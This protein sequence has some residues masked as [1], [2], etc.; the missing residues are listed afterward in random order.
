[1]GA[2][3]TATVGVVRET[4]DDEH[5]VALTPDGVRRVSALG[6][7]VLVET[8]AGR[9]A[10]FGDAD[11][12]GAGATIGSRDQVYA[13]SDLVLCVHAPVDAEALHEG[14]WLIGLL[15][16]LTDPALVARLAGAQVTMVSL[17]L[18]PR[19]LSRAQA[20]D[21]L[22]SQATVAGYKAALIAA[23]TYGGFFPMLMTAAGTTRP[24]EVLVLGAGVAGL[25]AIATARRLGAVV[26][27]HDVREAARADIASTGAAV[28]ALD[29]PSGTGDGGYARPLTDAEARAQQ[30]A[31]DAAIGRF[32]VVITT[33]QVPGGRPPLLVSE[34]ALAGLRPGSVVVDLAAG[35]LG[36]NVAGSRPGRT[37]V[38]A[39]GVTVVGAGDL[40]ATMPK[41]ASTAYSRNLAALLRSLLRDGTP[42]V[43]LGDE[44]VAGVVVTHGSEVV[45]PRVRAVLD[46][47]RE[48]RS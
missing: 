1:M 27:A 20:M 10:G 26:T 24:A 41:A 34:A 40:A 12:A 23:N 38:T 9:D 30:D 43:D 33:A 31:L 44:I 2:L 28:L 47:H 46:E 5:R 8:A 25:Q 6:V 14:Q 7:A 17:D 22:T 18:L 42:V 45:H 36:G 11:Y 29:T 32:D 35:P 21:A 3:M 16:P 19:T 48:V 37:L 15:F 4:A 39:G 13:T